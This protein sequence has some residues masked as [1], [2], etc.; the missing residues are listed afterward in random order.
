MP[1]GVAL[2]KRL[3]AERSGWGF[4]HACPVCLALDGLFWGEFLGVM[5][6]EAGCPEDAIRDRLNAPRPQRSTERRWKPPD[7]EQEQ[8]HV[9]D[10]SGLEP[11]AG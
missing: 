1:P 4:R 9:T 8:E 7:Q 11:A 10:A 5:E 2:A 3:G 6:C